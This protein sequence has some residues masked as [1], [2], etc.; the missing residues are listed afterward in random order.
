LLGGL[1]DLE[2]A[3]LVG[4]EIVAGST[5]L[6]AGTATKMIL[7]MITTGAMIRIGKT[8]GNRMIDLHPSNEKLRIRSR[9]MLRELAGVDDAAAA[10]LLAEAGGRLK[11]A[12]VMALAQVDA[13]TAQALLAASGGQV[14]A[15][16]RAAARSGE[17]GSQ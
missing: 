7:N 8:L 9:R 4:P 15:A 17:E 1:A 5:R 13:A 16:V 3:P 10:R 14:H 11:P 12:L 2:I 6:K